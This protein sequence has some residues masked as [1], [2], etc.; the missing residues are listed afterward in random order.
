ML[1]GSH[2]LSRSRIPGLGCL[3]KETVSRFGHE[4]T[5]R[6]KTLP[7]T[8]LRGP[9]EGSECRG[10]PSRSWKDNVKEWTG[11]SLSSLLRIASDRNRWATIKAGASLR[12]ILRR[13][14][15]TG[16]SLQHVE[17]CRLRTTSQCIAMR[18]NTTSRDKG[19]TKPIKMPF[20]QSNYV[21][22]MTKR[23]KFRF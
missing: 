1:S 16:I 18:P 8:L 5:C 13:R 15:V 9:V 17:C 3:R 4:S 2:C 7:K 11:Q 14:G 23:Q 10:R 6:R 20:G 22:K 21:V 12:V 19:A